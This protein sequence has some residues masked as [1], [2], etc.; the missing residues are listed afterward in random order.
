M[1]QN[2][3]KDNFLN[4]IDKIEKKHKPKA[5]KDKIKK[6]Q[7]KLITVKNINQYKENE[8]AVN[9]NTFLSKNVSKDA[10]DILFGENLA[11]TG[12][13]YGLKSNPIIGLLIS[14]IALVVIMFRQMI[15]KKKTQS[16]GN[17]GGNIGI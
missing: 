16:Q 6:K 10:G 7:E 17:V 8:I 3:E 2:I 1:D 12:E 11:R 15:N 9:I 14:S 13:Y 5:L 4:A